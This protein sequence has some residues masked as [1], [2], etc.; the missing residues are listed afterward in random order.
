VH[1]GLVYAAM[2]VMKFLTLCDCAESL[3]TRE[4]V[5]ADA[6]NAKTLRCLLLDRRLGAVNPSLSFLRWRLPDQRRL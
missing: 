1:F 6:R 4:A 2:D 3:A 5:F